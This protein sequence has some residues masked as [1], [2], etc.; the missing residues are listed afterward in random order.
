MRDLEHKSYEEWLRDLRLHDLE[1]GKLGG[2][3]IALYSCLKGV[4][5]EVGVSLFSCETSNRMRENGLKL[6]QGRFRLDIREQQCEW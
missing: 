3:L 2:D 4:C 6:C 1:K 5:G